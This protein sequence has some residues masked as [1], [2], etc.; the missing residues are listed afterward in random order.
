MPGSFLYNS[1]DVPIWGTGRGTGMI[2]S[3]AH[4]YDTY[5]TMDN[6]YMAV[7]AIEPQFYAQL[8]EGKF[9][10]TVILHL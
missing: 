5:R 1:R 6:D 2:D 7:G 3:G 8:I 9:F 10:C 4:F